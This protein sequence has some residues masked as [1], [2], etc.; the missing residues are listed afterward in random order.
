ME[1]IEIM[2]SIS[3]NYE[4]PIE[5]DSIEKNKI[6]TNISNQIIKDAIPDYIFSYKTYIKRSY[7]Q[8]NRAEIPWIAIFDE[9]LTKS[10]QKGFYIVYLFTNDYK[11]VYL[12]LNQGY[13]IYKDKFDSDF[14]MKAI[15]K[16]SNFWKENLC[17][18]NEKDGF[19]ISD[20]NLANIKSK[21]EKLRGYE[22]GTIYS[23]YYE[24]DKLNYED[25]NE[26]LRDLFKIN[27]VYMELKSKLVTSND[28]ISSTIN[29]ILN[30]DNINLINDNTI[31]KIKKIEDKKHI[32]PFTNTQRA[33]NSKV[34]INRDKNYLE[35]H[36]M[37]IETGIKGEELVIN[38]EKERLSKNNK[39]LPYVNK[40]IHTSVEKGDG[41]GY[42]I[43]SYDIIN[44]KVEKIFIEVK[45]TTSNRTNAQFFISQNEIDVSME[46]GDNYRIYF[47]SNYNDKNPN[48]QIIDRIKNNL[49][50]SPVNYIA[51]V[52]N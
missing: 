52:T 17:T 6:I 48:L 12:T 46:K 26:L 22:L 3:Q 32:I 49:E 8:G 9:E 19:T 13:S 2:Q 16:V 28:P 41:Y 30:E 7:G 27:T 24:I 21:N 40:I 10:A 43:E 33:Y 14:R 36:E 51:R 31:E 5:K 35:E 18:I 42:D 45:T 20:I 1:L 25:N 39:L 34:N 15:K 47:V 29:A 37:N 50:L 11:G 44:E 38:Y 4:Y 23:K